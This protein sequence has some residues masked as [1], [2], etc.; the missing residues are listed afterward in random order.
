MKDNNGKSIPHFKLEEA[1]DQDGC[2]ICRLVSRVSHDYLDNI[3]YELVND[4]DVHKEF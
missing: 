3:L 1:L 2:A 4:P